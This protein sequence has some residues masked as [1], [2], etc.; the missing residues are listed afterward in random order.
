MF[1]CVV[2]SWF[3]GEYTRTKTEHLDYVLGVWR[4]LEDAVDTECDG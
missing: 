1:R 3:A 4:E 2:I